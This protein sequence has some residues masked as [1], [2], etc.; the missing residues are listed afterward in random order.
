MVGGIA[1][2]NK[3]SKILKM[4]WN[5]IKSIIF[6]D[7]LKKKKSVEQSLLGGEHEQ[8]ELAKT[9]LSRTEARQ[10]LDRLPYAQSLNRRGNFDSDWTDE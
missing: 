8:E 3:S 5:K 1:V 2:Q 7:C 4:Y 6:E 10:T 9:G